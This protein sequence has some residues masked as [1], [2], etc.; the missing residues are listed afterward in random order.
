[1]FVFI[2]GASS[3]LGEATAKLLSK[4]YD[5]VLNGR[6]GE[7]LSSV[8]NECLKNGRKILLFPYDLSN[9]DSLAQALSTF[10]K[11]N[12][13]QIDTFIHFAGLTE[14]LP[15]SKT[16]YTVGLEVM[17][18]NYFS[19]TE[20][21]STLTKRRINGNALKNI[22]LVSSL[23]ASYGTTHQP[24]YC[25]SKGAVEALS[26]ALARDLAPNVRVN[27][28][29]PG[30]FQT[31]MWNTPLNENATGQPWNPATLVPVQGSAAVANVVDFLV[32]DQSSYLTGVNIP[33]D[34][35]ERFNIGKYHEK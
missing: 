32:S 27:T 13:I 20:I 12:D 35:G 30:N 18:V 19:A 2:T 26:R 29:T 25:S 11:T 7:R 1:M 3:G 9:V 17:N 24:H 31:R 4:Q 8:G 21:I 14:V 34:G 6:D 15:I 16:K 33:V 22:I 28:V 23:A 10:I 5:L